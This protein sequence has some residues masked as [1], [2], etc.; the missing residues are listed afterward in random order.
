MANITRLANEGVLVLACPFLDD[1]DLKGIYIFDVE[2]VEE[3]RKLTESDP[4]A[5]AGS[6]IMEMHPWYGSAGVME[7]NQIHK[8]VAK[9]KF[10]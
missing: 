5:Q 2:S 10:Q 4:A 1:G 7:I 9:I 3:A 6:L 8:K